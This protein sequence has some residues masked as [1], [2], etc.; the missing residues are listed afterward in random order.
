MN[1]QIEALALQIE[2]T[3]RIIRQRADILKAETNFTRK[4]ER[5]W[6]RHKW[7]WIAGGVTFGGALALLFKKRAPEKI[8]IPA[9][10]VAVPAEQGRPGM[11][12]VLKVLA[13]VA[14]PAIL[15]WIKGGAFGGRKRS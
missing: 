8:L 5:S 1:S 15:A 3:R 2:E 14:Q 9:K 7:I 4:L 13:G 6:S 10:Y 11:W 12:A